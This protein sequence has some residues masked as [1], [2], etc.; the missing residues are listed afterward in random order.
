M[1][2]L[3][4]TCAGDEEGGY[5][6]F[7][8]KPRREIRIMGCREWWPDLETGEGLHEVLFFARVLGKEAEGG[9]NVDAADLD[10]EDGA[11]L[12]RNAAV[13]EGRL[14]CRRRGHETE[15]DCMGGRGESRRSPLPQAY[16][17]AV[18]QHYIALK[19]QV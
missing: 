7:L 5:G 11:A 19:T 17:V 12:V 1:R 6:D 10:F 15:L 18:L 14:H 3:P 8:S 9:A 4:L 13:F 2:C 16:K